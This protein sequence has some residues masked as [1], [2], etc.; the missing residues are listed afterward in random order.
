MK[1]C[2]LDIH[3]NCD[4]L[5]VIGSGDLRL[6]L[7]VDQQHKHTVLA[8]SLSSLDVSFHPY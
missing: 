3:V 2:D 4:Q 5:L 1:C 6:V 7:A 8:L